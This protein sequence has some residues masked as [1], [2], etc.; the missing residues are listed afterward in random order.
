MLRLT[1]KFTFEMAHALS[2]Y[3]GACRHIH[4]HSYKLYVTVSGVP[5]E[6]ETS[7]KLGMVIDF[8]ELKK[9]VGRAIVD[10]YDHALVLKKGSLKEDFFSELKSHWRVEEVDFQP[11]CENMIVDMFESLAQRM[12][13]G[14]AL[15]ELKLYETENSYVTY[16]P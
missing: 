11:T 2:G 4:G 7:P 5:E 6:D 3:D 16:R 15:Y 14:V 10:R 1:R 13:E 12:P 8:S 9:L